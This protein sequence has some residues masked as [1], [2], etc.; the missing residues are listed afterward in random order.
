MLRRVLLGAERTGLG[1]DTPEGWS[2]SKREAR[3]QTG[4]M[5][6]GVMSP[7]EQTL[8]EQRAPSCKTHGVQVSGREA[9]WPSAA[10]VIAKSLPAQTP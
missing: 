3:F 6:R 10:G 7:Q 5:G 2:W 4:D 8:S 9:R 1:S